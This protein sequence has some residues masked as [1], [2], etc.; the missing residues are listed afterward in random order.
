VADNGNWSSNYLTG[1]HDVFRVQGPLDGLHEAC[2]GLAAKLDQVLADIGDA[3][4]NP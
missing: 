3:A 2:F 1:I 4:N